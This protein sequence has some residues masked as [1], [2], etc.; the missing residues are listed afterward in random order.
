MS[1]HLWQVVTVMTYMIF[2]QKR[3][4]TLWLVN[5]F[6]LGWVGR[7]ADG[8]RHEAW[9]TLEVLWEGLHWRTWAGWEHI[10]LSA[11][12][13]LKS[14]NFMTNKRCEVINVLTIVTPLCQVILPNPPN[15]PKPAK[16]AQYTSPDFVLW[17]ILRGWLLCIKFYIMENKYCDSYIFFVYFLLPNLVGSLRL[18]GS[19]RITRVLCDGPIGRIDGCLAL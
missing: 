6:D 14:I 8:P 12:L 5:K 3:V 7:Q 10:L 15:P 19:F 13:Q 9:P 2:R 18:K 16:T 17:L 4:P 11:P 1:R